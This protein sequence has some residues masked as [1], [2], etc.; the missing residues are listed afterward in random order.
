[1]GAE[2]ALL[3]DVAS[4]FIMFVAG[5]TVMVDSEVLPHVISFLPLPTSQLA[6]PSGVLSSC[7][8]QHQMTS[9]QVSPRYRSSHSVQR[10]YFLICLSK[11]EFK[12][13]QKA[14]CIM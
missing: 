10:S 8:R 2:G 14:L 7:L 3:G 13:Q 5:D 11:V 1:M 6:A 9:A 12:K 4:V